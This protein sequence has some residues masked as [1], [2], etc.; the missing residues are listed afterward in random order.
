MNTPGKVTGGGEVGS[1]KEAVKA[2]FGFTIHYRKGDSKPDGNLV[3][4]DHTANLRLKATSF[5]RLVI[6]GNQA[7]FTGSGVLDDGKEVR[8]TVKIEV[9]PDTFSISIPDLNGYEAGGPLSG[10]NL[11][12]HK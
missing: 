7:W 5:D 9:S 11:T 3:Y 12:I 2:A 6:D 4:Q 10:G 8:F 1:E